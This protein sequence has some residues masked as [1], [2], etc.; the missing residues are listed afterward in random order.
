VLTTDTKFKILYF[1]FDWSIHRLFVLNRA[2]KLV[3]F[4]IMIF[5][6]IC[7]TWDSS[8]KNAF[9]D[10]NYKKWC[11]WCNFVSPFLYNNPY[12]LHVLTMDTNVQ[13]M[14]FMFDWLINRQFVLN[15]GWKR[16]S[17]QMIVD[18]I[19]CST[20]CIVQLK[21]CFVLWITRSGVN[22]VN[23]FLLSYLLTL[24]VYLCSQ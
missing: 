7:S 23:L 6:N 24:M 13:I 11:K 8:T 16:D 10:V 9:W 18:V 4:Q 15:T 21:T 17:L 2:W 19:V 3:S 14:Y 22:G 1:M 12:G 5:V 20:W